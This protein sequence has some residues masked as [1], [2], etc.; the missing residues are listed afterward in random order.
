MP[1]QTHI[2]PILIRH[3][4]RR[5]F[6]NDTIQADGETLTTVIR[7][8]SIVSVPGLMTAFFLQ[9]Q[10]TRIPGRPLWGAIEDQYFFVLFSFIVMGAVAI[11]EWEMLFP[12]RLDFLILSPL[13]VRPVQML[14]AKAAALFAFLALFLFSSNVC[15][16]ILLP[17]VSKT[18]FWRQLYAHAVAVSLA[19]LFAVLLILA[20]GSILLC[21]LDA[22]RFRLASPLLQMISVIALLLLL[23]QYIEYGDTIQQLLSSH[24]GMARW[25]PPIWFLGVYEH[26][27]RGDAAPPFAPEMARY[28]LR[29]TAIT[30]LVVL[31]TYPLAWKRM[32]TMA[33]EGISS[34]RN[35]PARWSTALLHRLVRSPSERAVFHFIGQTIVR[36]NR[37]QVYLAMYA[38]TGLAIAIDCAVTLHPAARTF[39]PSLSDKGLHATLP[40]LL[41]WLIAGLRTAFAFPIN[42]A[43]RWSFRTTGVSISDCAA[44]ARRWVLLCALAPTSA[45]LAILRLAHW[46]LRHLLVQFVFGLC[47]SLLLTDG[48]FF[49][50]RV[51]FNQPRMPGKTSLPLMLTLF[52][53]VL[54][55]FI[56]EIIHMEMKLEKNLPQLLLL[57]L[58]TAALHAGISILRRGPDEVEEEME[59]YDGEFQLLGLSRQ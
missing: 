13:S 45:I 41:F 51:P 58:G 49:Q 14:T 5:F 23:L 36:N 47:L 44:A 4:F 29:A 21:L 6:D 18:Q 34:K 3:F 24:L 46:D 43:A 16:A 11:F 15:G 59:G 57:I 22:A 48:F 7:A 54:P 55:P 35:Q 39:Q 53:G 10:Y 30:A 28:A 40:L 56:F 37:Y 2:T 20:L 8:I 25:M 52:L 42:L 31:L 12:D 38:G 17:A 26:L 19:G 32:R 27:L 9:T 33:I 1:E 50:P